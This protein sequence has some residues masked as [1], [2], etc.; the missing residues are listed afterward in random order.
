[1]NVTDM[2]NNQ[3]KVLDGIYE[4]LHQNDTPEVR[5]ALDEKCGPNA[6][7]DLEKYCDEMSQAADTAIELERLSRDAQLKSKPVSKSKPA[8]KPEPEEDDESFLD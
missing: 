1:M 4:L 6:F 5:A 3:K 7:D 8:P 2:M